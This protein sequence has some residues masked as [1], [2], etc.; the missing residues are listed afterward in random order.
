MDIDEE[1]GSSAISIWV[2]GK[3]ELSLQ[4]IEW[5]IG[6]MGSLRC[7]YCKRNKPCKYVDCCMK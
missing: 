2:D 6:T 5:I 4:D 7:P 3:I 1:D